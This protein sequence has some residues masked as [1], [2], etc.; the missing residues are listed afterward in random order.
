M[1]VTLQVER[2]VI[3]VET[4]YKPIDG[5]ALFRIL[6]AEVAKRM[7]MIMSGEKGGAK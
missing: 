4:D 7:D 3:A 6:L 5:P 2:H 1:K